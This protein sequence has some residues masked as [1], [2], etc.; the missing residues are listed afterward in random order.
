[1]DYIQEAYR[2]CTERVKQAGSSFYQGM[3][4]L[5]R[6]KRMAM[7]AIYAWSRVCDDAVDDYS[8]EEA[9]HQLSRAATLYEE[10]T[11]DNWQDASDAISIALGDA[12]HRFHL[13]DEPFR[14]LLRGMQMDMTSRLYPTYQDLE[15][16]CLNVAGSIGTLCVEVFGYKDSEARSLGAK[17]GVALQLTNILRDLKEDAQ[18][19]RCYLPVEDLEKY[20]VQ[21]SDLIEPHLTPALI[22]LL[23]H[24]ADIAKELYIEAT[25]LFDLIESDSILC[26]RLLYGVYYLI[27]EKIEALGFDVWNNHRVRVSRRETLQLMGGALWQQNG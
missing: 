27:L 16:Y 1:M 20:Q 22:A 13:S 23:S 10:A 11:K 26:L 24:E 3:R 21:P 9:R 2:V 6:P 4:L 25:G 14:A 15:E 12:I 5:P 17:L 7:Y 18:R 8:G 19:G